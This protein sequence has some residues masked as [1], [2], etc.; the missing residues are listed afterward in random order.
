MRAASILLVVFSLSAC[1]QQTLREDVEPYTD[2]DVLRLIQ[3]GEIVRNAAVLE[4]RDIEISGVITGLGKNYLRWWNFQLSDV[5]NPALTI[6]CFESEWHAQRR[7]LEHQ[8]LR[9]ARAE[10]REIRVA[11][12]LRAGLMLEIDWLEFDGVKY[13]TDRVAPD[14]LN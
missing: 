8:L 13:D 9:I 11:G 10:K 7:G 4:G 6:T 12:R 14:T 2:P 3:V 5:E 1:N